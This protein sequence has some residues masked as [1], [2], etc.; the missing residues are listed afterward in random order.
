MRLF[1]RWIE[2]ALNMTVQRSQ[3]ADPRKHRWAAAALGH[4]DQQLPLPLAIP[5][6]Y[7][8]PSEAW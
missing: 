4:E 2:D 5:V 3:D 6:Q 7:V 8:R 1:A